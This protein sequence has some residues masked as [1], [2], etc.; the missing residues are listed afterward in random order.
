[1]IS[2][3]IQ[4]KSGAVVLMEVEDWEELFTQLDSTEWDSLSAR[5]EEY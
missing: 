1:M 3:A 5:R 4:L 2:A